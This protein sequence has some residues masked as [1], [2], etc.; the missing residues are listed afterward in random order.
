MMISVSGGLIGVTLGITLA[1]IVHVCRNPNH[2]YFFFYHFVLWGG[3]RCR[4]D[5]WN[6]ARSQGREPGSDYV[7]T[8]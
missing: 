7:P 1:Y 2:Y 6:C 8:L 5:I 3:C 4:T